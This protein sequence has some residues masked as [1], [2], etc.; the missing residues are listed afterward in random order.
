MH[1]RRSVA[2]NKHDSAPLIRLAGMLSQCRDV[3]GTDCR[4]QIIFSRGTVAG[5]HDVVVCCGELSVPEQ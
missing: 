2:N 1:H 4:K 3:G 5:A